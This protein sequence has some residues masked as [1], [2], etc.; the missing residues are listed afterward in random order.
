MDALGGLPCHRLEIDPVALR[1]EICCDVLDYAQLHASREICGAILD[2]VELQALR[3]L[4]SRC[5]HRSPEPY[6]KRTRLRAK[7]SLFRRESQRLGLCLVKPSDDDHEQT[8][9]TSDSQRVHVVGGELAR[10]YTNRMAAPHRGIG[11]P[12]RQC[13]GAGRLAP[14]AIRSVATHRL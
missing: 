11:L 13:A 6:P 7:S 5:G 10:K 14:G 3:S 1:R 8:A 12:C 4:R 2:G 9:N